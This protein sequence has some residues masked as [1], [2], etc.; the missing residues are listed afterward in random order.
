M[1]RATKRQLLDFITEIRPRVA[2]AQTL[3]E[4][5][6]TVIKDAS[7]A[8]RE[9]SSRYQK[10]TAA[11]SESD[12]QLLILNISDSKAL[13]AIRV[14]QEMP[15]LTRTQENNLHILATEVAADMELALSLTKWRRRFMSEA[16]R[17]RAETAAGKLLRAKAAGSRLLELSFAQEYLEHKGIAATLPDTNRIFDDFP[18]SGEVP[19]W[20]EVAI[21]H[22]EPIWFYSKRSI[23][24]Y[25]EAVRS[26][27]GAYVEYPTLRSSALHFAQRER[28][29]AAKIAF[30]LL[31]LEALAKTTNSKR[32]FRELRRN[33][34]QTLGE[35]ESRQHTLTQINGIGETTASRLRAGLRHEKA[36]TKEETTLRIN[37]KNPSPTQ[38][39]LLLKLHQLSLYKTFTE[40][41]SEDEET[42][43]WSLLKNAHSQG[44]VGVVLAG[45]LEAEAI[46]TRGLSLAMTT[47]QLLPRQE[48]M[49]L[50]SAWHHFQ[51]D[52]AAF[53]NLLEELGFSILRVETIRGGLPAEI[54][55]RIDKQPLDT[56]ALNVTLRN[57]QHFAARFALVQKKVV[58][59]DEMGLG[60]TI[61]ALA[62]IGH[63]HTEGATHFVV[64]C[65]AAVLDNWVREVESRSNLQCHKLHGPQKGIYLKAWQRE[66]GVAVMTYGGLTSFAPN[67]A[68]MTDL[69]M[70]VVDEAHYVKNPGAQRTKSAV[71]LVSKVEH[72]M[73]MTGTPLE[74][75]QEEFARLTAMVQPDVKLDPL[76]YT[77]DEFRDELAPVY[78][79]RRT[80]DVLQELPELI[81]VDE[82][83]TMSRQDREAYARAL[84]G[85]DDNAGSGWSRSFHDARRAPMLQGDR[86]AKLN[87]LVEIVEEAE[88]NGRKVLIFSFY[89]AV[90]EAVVEALDGKVHGPLTG[91][92][93]ASRRQD[94]IDEF[95]R[96]EGGACLVSQIQ[97][98]G[99]GLNI[100]AAS[101][102]IICEPQVKPTTEWQATG[103]A[104]RM[105]QSE[106]VTAYRLLANEG[107]E[108]KLVQRLAEKTRAFKDYA[109]DS[110]LANTTPEAFDASASVSVSEAEEA[111]LPDK[112]IK[113]IVAEIIAEERLRLGAAAE[114]G[115]AGESDITEGD[116]AEND[117]AENDAAED[118]WAKKDDWA[119]EDQAEEEQAE[120]SWSETKPAASRLSEAVV[121]GNWE[122]R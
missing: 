15:G 115:D 87:R 10:A 33:G 69:K 103:R 41:A 86:S 79:R 78:L 97:A 50:E 76:M 77:P 54:A 35:L 64:V 71:R 16:T 43:D 13:R 120:E 116:G 91:S 105:G 84:T 25:L 72:A 56:S 40:R 55:E 65:P 17:I 49:S 36:R 45:P 108:I 107:L 1:D 121:L 98:G 53:Y 3:L 112:E 109:E 12:L 21:Q 22:P 93:S 106:S 6:Q 20:F 5:R 90:L 26:I 52:P 57:Y 75:H 7:Q 39:N 60:K 28:Y 82:L 31:P 104:H 100:Q 44:A 34:I 14:A 4:Y 122:F 37:V 113:Q 114:Q 48:D 42:I 81:E 118:D 63:L 66:G 59:G 85:Q 62:V 74:N 88:E 9:L 83:V 18:H 46:F 101:V 96:V 23:A 24:A 67:L 73:L 58:I 111:E 11:S 110:V 119:K 80:K 89:R 70:V 30:E 38:L 117:A 95:T 19:L 29:E 47:S 99:V 51:E 27:Q 102:V 32:G 61:E 94:M 2:E 92:V 8:Q 68:Q